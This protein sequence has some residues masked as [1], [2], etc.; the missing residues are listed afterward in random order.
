V[1]IGKRINTSVTMSVTNFAA[2]AVN[3]FTKS[4]SIMCSGHP[5]LANVFL[6]FSFLSLYFEFE[7]R[8]KQINNSHE[9][10]SF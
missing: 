5:V 7:F 10:I 3:K 6:V 8:N 1:I 9:N 2:M 4:P